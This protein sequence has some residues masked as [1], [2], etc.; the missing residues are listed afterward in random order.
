MVILSWAIPGQGGFGH[1]NCASNAYIIEEMKQRGWVYLSKPSDYLRERC[2]GA[3]WCQDT[4][5]VFEKG[6]G[7]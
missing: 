2:S 4:V 7:I 1:V 6:G 5:M 3:E